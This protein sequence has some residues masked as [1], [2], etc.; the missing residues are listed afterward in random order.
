MKSRFFRTLGKGLLILGAIVF[1]ML[2]LRVFINGGFE[3][4]NFDISMFIVALFCFVPGYM[5][6]R[7]A[8]II[9]RYEKDQAENS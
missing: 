1:F 6:I 3:A 2:Y 7:V 9:S 8:C 4:I 5:L